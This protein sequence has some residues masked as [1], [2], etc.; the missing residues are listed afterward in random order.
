[1]PR[2]PRLKP[3]SLSLLLLALAC[4]VLSN[5]SAPVLAVNAAPQAAHHKPSKSKQPAPNPPKDAPVPF[6]VGEVLNYSIAWAAF[7][8]AATAQLTVAER[9][10]FS[11]AAAWH[12]QAFAH[13]QNTVRSLF[14]VDDQFDSYTS[15]STLDGLQYELHL[16]ELGRKVDRVYQFQPQGEKPFSQGPAVI[17]PPGARDPLGAFYS[18]RAVDW[19]KTPEV[20]APVYDGH[21]IYEM[22]ASLDSPSE[23]IVVPAGRFSTSRIS[24]TP[25]Q[26][27]HAVPGIQVTVWIAHDA[28]R[29]PAQILAELPFGTLHIALS[30]ASP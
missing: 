12:F 6:R 1:M 30:P 26:N 4:L 3:L 11:A 15:A 14:T 7:T 5:S 2:A 28:A 16:N 25:F 20:V 10:E 27:H 17:V 19:Q 24:V 22:H 13:T 18:L 29:T 23:D 8:Y 9:R 21:D